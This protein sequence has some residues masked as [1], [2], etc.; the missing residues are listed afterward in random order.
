MRVILVCLA[1]AVSTLACRAQDATLSSLVTRYAQANDVP[2]ALVNRVILRESRFNPRLRRGRSFW[3]LM[4]LR[5]ATARSLGYHGRPEGLLD[6]ETNLAYGVLYLA[7]AW[8]V[9]RGDAALAIRLYSSGYYYVAKRR[10]LR[11]LIRTVAVRPA[12]V[13][14]TAAP[15]A[16][17]R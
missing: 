12:L 15:A 4:Q 5:P 3:G 8:R 16:P 7:N 11:K 1:L 17:P 14:A 9:A 10:G 6:P 13:V 2:E